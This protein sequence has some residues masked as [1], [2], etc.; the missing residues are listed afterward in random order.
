MTTANRFPDRNRDMQDGTERML[1]A[2]MKFED[3]HWY[4]TTTG[5]GDTNDKEMPWLALAGLGAHLP[6]G[7]EAEVFALSQGSDTHSKFA[8]HVTMPKKERKWPQGAN[9]LQKLDDP[10][11]ALQFGKKRAHLD[12]K[13]WAAGKDGNVE[14]DEEGNLWLRPAPGKKIYAA[15]PIEVNS[16]PF[17][18]ET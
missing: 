2:S 15:V 14:R 13:V 10:D 5:T 4:V 7:A 12:A 17:E 18:P 9:G 8:I 11:T 6:D 3:G 16:K 1:H